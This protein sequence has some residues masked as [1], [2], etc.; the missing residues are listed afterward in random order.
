[1]HTV[2]LT[3]AKN[4]FVASYKS[5][6]TACHKLNATTGEWTLPSGPEK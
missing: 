1:M 3:G 6:C 2:H 4:E 5:D